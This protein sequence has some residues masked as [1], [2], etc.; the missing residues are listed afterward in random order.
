MIYVKGDATSPTSGVICHVCNDIGA[1]GAGF[2][3]AL[4]RRWRE[5]E[6]LYRKWHREG[7]WQGKKFKLGEVQFVQVG[8]NLYVANMIAQR[9][10]YNKKLPPIRYRALTKCLEEVNAFALTQGLEIHAPKFGAGLAGG[11]WKTIEQII[12]TTITAPMTV[13]YL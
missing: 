10:I 7:L 4:S 8:D 5:P 3:L 13:Y 2:V 12:Q 1:W 6:R 9:G 11:D